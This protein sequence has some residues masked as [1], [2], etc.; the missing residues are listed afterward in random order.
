MKA[1]KQP[2]KDLQYSLSCMPGQVLGPQAAVISGNF[3]RPKLKNSVQDPNFFEELPAA[4]VQRP[5][6]GREA[7]PDLEESVG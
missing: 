2:H 6:N 4:P 1:R 5:T 7:G 3:C